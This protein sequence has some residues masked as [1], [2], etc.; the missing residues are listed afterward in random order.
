MS[1]PYRNVP[2]WAYEH[3]VTAI[4]VGPGQPPPI[5]LRRLRQ[6]PMMAQGWQC[7]VC[8][9]VMAPGMPNCSKCP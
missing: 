4:E 8:K 5:P 7:P 2:K 6:A 9:R 1:V 3:G